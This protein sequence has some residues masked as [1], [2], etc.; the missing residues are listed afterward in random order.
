M[1]WKTEP[2]VALL[3]GYYYTNYRGESHFVPLMVTIMSRQSAEE[4]AALDETGHT[5]VLPLSDMPVPQKTI[6]DFVAAQKEARDKERSKELERMNPW[7]KKAP[8]RKKR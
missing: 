2:P 3:Q 5:L 6:D 8:K 7:M 4:T 1:Y